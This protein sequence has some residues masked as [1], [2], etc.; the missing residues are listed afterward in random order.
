MQNVNSC[1]QGPS[2]VLQMRTRYRQRGNDLGYPL[3]L[4]S[5][6]VPYYH[7]WVSGRITTMAGYVEIMTTITPMLHA[8]N[9]SQNEAPFVLQQ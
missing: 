5:L 3:L 2:L 7:L 9:S 1:S 8:M 6:A 4:C